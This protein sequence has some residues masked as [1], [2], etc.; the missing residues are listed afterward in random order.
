MPELHA[1]P[2]T[3]AAALDEAA[4]L[5]AHAADVDDPVAEARQLLLSLV[6]Q[7]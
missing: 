4:A 3:V 1:A 5:L 7:P 6:D 2:A